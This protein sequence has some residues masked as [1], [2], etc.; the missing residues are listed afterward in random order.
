MRMAIWQTS[1]TVELV[2]LPGSLSGCP[3][4]CDVVPESLRH[5]LET[6]SEHDLKTRPNWKIC[7]LS[8]LRI[9]TQHSREIVQN[10]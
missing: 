3:R 6:Y 10:E 9:G 8:L 5:Y 7:I 4:L 1:P 2:S